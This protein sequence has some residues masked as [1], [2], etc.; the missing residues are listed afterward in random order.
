MSHSRKKTK[1]NL[2]MFLAV[3]LALLL[4]TNILG[5]SLGIGKRKVEI[6]FIDEEEDVLYRAINDKEDVAI[7]IK[8]NK[9]MERFMCIDSD[10]FD[11]FVEE[12]V[13]E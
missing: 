9:S 6:W 12:V 1:G 2:R 4:L 8:N 3:L 7:P 13:N 5:C 11:N 10:E